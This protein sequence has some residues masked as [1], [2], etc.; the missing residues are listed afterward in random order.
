MLWQS[1]PWQSDIG[2][3]YLRLFPISILW[4]FKQFSFSFIGCKHI[5]A[6]KT[7]IT[8]FPMCA[9]TASSLQDRS[10]LTRKIFPDAYRK[11]S[12]YSINVQV[13]AKKKCCRRWKILQSRQNKKQ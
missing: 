11:N 4:D 13:L 5:Q 1:K 9:I 12:N 2:F 10:V 8:I 6:I 3:S 7:I